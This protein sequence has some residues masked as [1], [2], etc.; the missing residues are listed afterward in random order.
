MITKIF[1][2][3]SKRAKVFDLLLSH[4]HM[5]YTKTD[6]AECAEI[7]RTTLNKFIDEL[8]EYGII[9]PTGKLRNAT[10]F[11]INMDSTITRALNSFQNQ[12]ADIEIEK[13]M[14]EY[15][16]EVDPSLVPI[17]PF[18]EIVRNEFFTPTLTSSLSKVIPTYE[19]SSTQTGEI[20]ASLIGKYSKKPEELVIFSP[21]TR[22]S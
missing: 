11:Q 8:V 15:R 9:K 20:E 10:L 18:E 1:G 22:S 5:K 21:I 14:Q 17:R 2:E 6:I 7:S 3:E 12:L 13:M 16:E 19:L 4:P